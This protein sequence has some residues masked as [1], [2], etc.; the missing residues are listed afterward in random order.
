MSRIAVSLT[1]IFQTNNDEAFS[2]QAIE[3][4]KNQDIPASAGGGRIGESF[5]NLSTAAKL[6]KSKKSK[7]TK[8]KKSDLPKANF[9]KINFGTDF[10]TP[11]AKKA[12]IHLQKAFIE[13]LILRY[14]DTKCHLRIETDTL[15]YAISEVLSK[16]TSDYSDQYSS[17]HVTYKD[18]NSDFSKSKIS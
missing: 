1:S 17:G 14:F 15:G 3:N 11:K 16:M 18:L 5:E 10:L 4:K 7:S 2:T 6:A 8:S 13:A 12:F 9:A